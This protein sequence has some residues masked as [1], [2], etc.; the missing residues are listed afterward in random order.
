MESGDWRFWIPVDAVGLDGA[1]V[2]L[3]A[4][5]RVWLEQGIWGVCDAVFVCPG[6]GGGE[7]QCP[8]QLEDAHAWLCLVGAEFLEPL[9]LD[10]EGAFGD[11]G[12]VW[13]GSNG[14]GLVG[15]QQ[16]LKWEWC[17]SGIEEACHHVRPPLERLFGSQDVMDGGAGLGPLP[18]GGGADVVQGSSEEEPK[19]YWLRWR[20]GLVRSVRL[21]YRLG[22]GLEPGGW[23]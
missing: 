10:L 21:L 15:F 23:L 2:L 3:V 7:V 18:H 8:G 17:E 22:R 11:H 1:R 4:V 20:Q 6:L 13:L 14:V 5:A 12:V 19:P 16:G 9:D